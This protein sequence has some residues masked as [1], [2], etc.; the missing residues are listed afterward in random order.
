VDRLVQGRDGNFYGTTNS[1]GTDNYGTVFKITPSGALTTLDNFNGTD[2]YDSAGAMVLGTDG[3]FYLPVSEGGAHGDGTIFRMTATGTLT[4]LHSFDG[5]DG[6]GPFM[7][8]QDTDGT[9][10]GLTNFPPNDG[11][12]FD[13][14]VGLSAFVETLPT[15]GKVGTK[16]TILGTKLKGATSV[17]FNGTAAT[18]TVVSSS[19]IDAMVPTGATT[20][21]VR[22][23]TPLH[24]FSSNVPFRVTK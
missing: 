24:K 18:F 11:T 17:S 13:L 5:T 9:F 6:A 2:G 16:V 1:G 12:V 19:E 20:G 23:I 3:N 4:A 15:R 7:L 8:I 14:S 10:Y 21:K 22:V